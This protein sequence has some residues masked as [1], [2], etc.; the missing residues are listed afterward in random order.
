MR[1]VPQRVYWVSFF[2]PSRP[3]SWSFFR[4]GTTGMRRERMMETLM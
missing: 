4:A 2:R 3:S 1:T